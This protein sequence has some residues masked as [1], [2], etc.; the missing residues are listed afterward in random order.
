MAAAVAF[1]EL[2]DLL[3]RNTLSQ[4]FVKN[5]N[6]FRKYKKVCTFLKVCLL[7]YVLTILG[8]TRLFLGR[9]FDD[10]GVPKCTKSYVLF[11]KVCLFVC[12]FVCLLVYVL[13]FWAYQVVPWLGVLGS[14][15][16]RGYKI[17]TPM[18]ILYWQQNFLYI[19]SWS[20]HKFLVMRC[21]KHQLARKHPSVTD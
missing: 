5:A 10:Q 17:L 12:L 4:Y 9:V 2:L 14:R 1:N 21:C 7:V 13:A 15:G 18:H 20:L 3:I 11:F 19:I 6:V 8:Y 16:S